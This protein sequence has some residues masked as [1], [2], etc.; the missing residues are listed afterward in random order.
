VVD[1]DVS[2]VELFRMALQAEDYDVETV[3]TGEQALDALK[4]TKFDLVIIDIM[5][6]DI[7]GDRVVEKI[8]EK[9]DETRVILLTGHLSYAKRIDVLKLGISE[10]LLKP[11]KLNELIMQVKTVLEKPIFRLGDVNAWFESRKWAMRD[12][13][14]S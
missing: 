3:F 1:D 7:R 13:A 4:G 5:L 9:N 8:R 6:P 14:E 11:I 2:I 10:I 12:Y